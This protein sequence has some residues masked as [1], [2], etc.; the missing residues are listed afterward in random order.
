MNNN[1]IFY[2]NMLY[3]NMLY[4]NMLYNN[5]LYNNMLYNNMLYN[6]RFNNIGF[7]E[8]IYGIAGA[9]FFISAQYRCL[10]YFKKILN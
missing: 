5:M 10:L 8:T 9:T 6:K 7:L 3:N 1:N 4:N 2:N